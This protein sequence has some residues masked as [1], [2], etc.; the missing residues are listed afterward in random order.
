MKT[1]RIFLQRLFITIQMYFQNGLANHAAACAYAFL[2]SMVPT[3]LLTTF[4]IFIAFQSSPETISALIGTIPI[5]NSL[6]DEQWLASDL[7]NLSM[8]FIP[9]LIFIISVIWAGRILALSLQRGLRTIFPAAKKRNALKNGF[10]TLAIEGALIIFVF[11]VIISSRT[12]LRF[13]ELLD[14]L[15]HASFIKYITSQ[16]GGQVF[17][18]SLLSFASFLVYILIPVKPPK[19]TSAFIGSVFSGICY[20]CLAF[21]LRYI[22]D[23]GRYNFLYGTFGNLIIILVNVYFFF[24]FFFIG[25]QFAYVIDAFKELPPSLFDVV[26]KKDSVLNKAIQRYKERRKKANI[27]LD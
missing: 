26:L 11:I 18:I 20:F 1:I 13:Y 24:M 25:A 15:P 19:K 4:L 5:L 23:R 9:A 8:S 12:A 14:F 22:L 10:I 27:D 16:T 21:A 3:L 2:L 7:F 17:Y 6:F